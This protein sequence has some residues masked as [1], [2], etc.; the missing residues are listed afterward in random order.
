M[1]LWMDHKAASLLE[2]DSLDGTLLLLHQLLQ[3]RQQ[4]PNIALL[5]SGKRDPTNVL[6][7][8]LLHNDLLQACLLGLL[9][10]IVKV[11]DVVP[12]LMILM[13]VMRL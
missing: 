11:K 4:I 1:D 9:L 6:L 2:L 10:Q 5:G 8:I 12:Q 13:R 7:L 3:P